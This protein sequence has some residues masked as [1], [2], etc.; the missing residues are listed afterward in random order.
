MGLGK[1]VM[2]VALCIANPPTRNEKYKAT[3]VVCTPAL[4]KQWEREITK[5]ATE[6]AFERVSFYCSGSRPT[7]KGAMEELQKANIVLTTYNEVMRSYPKAEIPEE[8]DSSEKLKEWWKGTWEDREMLHK[9]RFYRVI[10]DESQAIKNHLSQT[11]IACR[12]LMAKHR[13]A[14]SGTPIMNRVEELYSYFKYLRVDFTGSFSEFTQHFC[15]EGSGDC[16]KR[17]H[18]IL[19]QI[20]I[21]RTMD[22]KVLGHP[23]VSLPETHQ[24]TERLDFNNVERVIYKIV[25]RRFIRAINKASEQGDLDRKPGYGIVMFLRLRQMAAHVFLIQEILQEMFE[26]DSIERLEA[27]TTGSAITDENKD[28]R[29]IIVALRRMVAA[30]GEPIEFTPD[31]QSEELDLQNPGE[32]VVKL[33]KRLIKLRDSSKLDELKA[34]QLCQKCGNIAEFPYVT[35]CLHVYCKECLEFLAYEAS[36]NDQ[37]HT[38]CRTCGTSYTKTEP[39]SGLKELVIDDFTDLSADL[40]LKGKKSNNGK[41]NMHWVAYDDELVMSAK[42]LGVQAQIEKW[43]EEDPNKKI[44]IFSQFLMMSVSK[45][46]NLAVL[47]TRCRMSIL[48]KMCQRKNWAYCNVCIPF[49]ATPQNY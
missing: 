20:M 38:L 11:S 32:L 2:A 30:K 29:A 33:R 22:D 13:W 19:D 35:S 8:I 18:C 10:L 3:L 23:I 37:D 21:R 40:S 48:E 4:L 7:G 46:Y 9:A 39:C 24:A 26:M 45:P 15:I 43:L 27:A 5:H 31:R 49:F 25:S 36:K 14:L 42:T 47:L 44:I 12:A 6:N 41:V 17:L 1:T 16:N 28:A 34:E